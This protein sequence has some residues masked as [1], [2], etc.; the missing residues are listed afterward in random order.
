M[1][2]RYHICFAADNNYIHIMATAMASILENNKEIGSLIHFWILADNL[3]SDN[4]KKLMEFCKR[5]HSEIDFIDVSRQLQ[6]IV[7]TGASAWNNGSFGTYSRLFLSQ[8]IPAYVTRILYLDSDV[9]ILGNL[10]ELLEMDFAEN[11]VLLATRDIVGSFN[12]VF[13][14]EIGLEGKNY[15]NAGVLMIDLNKWREIG[16]TDLIL[17]H[18]RNV[19]SIYPFVDQDVINVVLQNYIQIIS[20]KYDYFSSCK[21]FSTKQLYRMFNLG[22]STMFYPE[23][24]FEAETK[25]PVIIHFVGVLFYRP[26]F[27]NSNNPYREQ[28]TDYFKLTPFNGMILD[29]RHDRKMFACL[30]VAYRMLPAFL[31]VKVYAAIRKFWKVDVKA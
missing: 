12:P 11:A 31:F 25:N 13:L 9:I 16:M 2:K 24:Y 20:P 22:E 26:W 5:Y 10:K 19:R 14:R 15:V 1:D 29:K 27:T 4:R 18:M 8:L 6:N 3:S 30:A 28:W 17:E 23:E 21:P 7:K